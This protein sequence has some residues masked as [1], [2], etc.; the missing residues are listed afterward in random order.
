MTYNYNYI[1][2]SCLILSYQ[3][4][5]DHTILL[6]RILLQHLPGFGTTS[7]VILLSPGLYVSYKSLFRC[8]YWLLRVQFSRFCSLSSSFHLVHHS[9]SISFLTHL[10]TIN[11]PLCK[12]YS[13]LSFSDAGFSHSITFL[14]ILNISKRMLT[15]FSK[16]L[17]PPQ[18]EFLVIS[19]PQQL[20]KLN[21]L[22]LTHDL[23]TMSLFQG[24]T[25]RLGTLVSSLITIF[26]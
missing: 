1:V 9:L 13:V 7:E 21:S 16:K 10:E 18:T 12:W 5:I 20:A 11:C 8:Q 25:C 24:F 2:L 15:I 4:I 6:Q 3:C 23:R 26:L 14:E 19:L 17:N 22:T